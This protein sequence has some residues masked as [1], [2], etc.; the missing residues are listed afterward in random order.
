MAN[1]V[2]IQATERLYPDIE[3]PKWI[4]SKENAVINLDF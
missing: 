2:K 1:N 4:T 3:L